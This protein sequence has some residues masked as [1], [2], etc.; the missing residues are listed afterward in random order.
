MLGHDTGYPLTTHT[1]FTPLSMDA[2]AKPQKLS[3]NDWKGCGC[4]ISYITLMLSVNMGIH[5]FASK[6]QARQYIK[7]K[8]GSCKQLPCLLI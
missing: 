1:E 5:G 3:P 6:E 7:W 8:K 4:Y 2:G